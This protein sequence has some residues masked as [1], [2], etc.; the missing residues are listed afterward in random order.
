M[1]CAHLTAIAR[2]NPSAPMKWLCAK[3]CLVGDILDYGCGRGKDVAWLNSKVDE[4]GL[5]GQHVIGFDPY[6]AP[7]TIVN[8]MSN[9]FDT[10]TCNFVLNVI[11]GCQDR[12]NVIHHIKGL[13]RP[14]GRAYVAIRADKKKLNGF[15]KRGTFQTYVTILPAHGFTLIHKTGSYEL[16]EYIKP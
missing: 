6:Y 4:E 14:N 13:L 7:N 10:I 15:T 3:D 11:E 8:G 16:Y 5:E 1:S 12:E 2:K 9:C